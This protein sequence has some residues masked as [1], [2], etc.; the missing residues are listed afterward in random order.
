M[1]KPNNS[2][3][4]EMY[5]GVNLNFVK[6]SG[7]DVRKRI[8]D[9]VEVEPTK[10]A[11]SVYSYRM[12]GDCVGLNEI[13]NVD[14]GYACVTGDLSGEILS[15]RNPY[16]KELEN[17]VQLMKDS[18]NAIVF[19]NGGLF[20]YVPKSRNGQ[21]LSYQDQVAYFYSLFKDLAQQGK[22]V[23]MVRGT[24][25]HR[26]L[27]NH[28]IDVYGIL[29]EALG[30]HQK[31]CNEALVNIELQHDIVGKADVGIRTI[32]WN[33]TAT[34]GA[35]IG[36]KMEERA[37][38]R[39]GAD[40]YLARTTMNYFKTAVVGESDGSHIIRKPIYLI[41]GGPYTPFK[42]AMTA[43]AEHNSIKDGELAPN[44]FWYK[45]T[46]EENPQPQGN[47]R[48]YFVKVN[49]IQYIAHQINFQGTDKLT[50]GIENQICSE[51]D[52]AVQYF[53]DKYS[54]SVTPDREAGR[55]RIREIL[56]ENRTVARRNEAIQLSI[57]RKKG[58]T[59]SPINTGLKD[60][61]SNVPV[62][63]PKTYFA[64]ETDEISDDEMSK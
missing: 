8:L 16:L 42:G 55:Q 9:A 40:I 23:A 58:K 13:S 5:E 34:T 22:I 47:E 46:V 35:Y 32:N 31:V 41:S 49:P 18:E 36:R 10:I 48:P 19:L 54:A 52:G 1:A 56:T 28:Q 14:M 6:K 44:S 12:P 57:D 37:T 4:E 51:V 3:T 21:L 24:E 39:G 30:L 63:E 61:G 20:T 60:L 25:E 50:A 27:K 26:I 11:P 7:D 29:Q 53:I 33:N 15:K 2:I 59:T 38:K 17:N 62:K 64:D 45:I 43:G